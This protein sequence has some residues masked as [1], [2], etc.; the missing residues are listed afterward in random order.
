[1]KRVS[2]VIGCQSGQ[3]ILQQHLGEAAD[4]LETLG[5]SARVCES[6]KGPLTF[7]KCTF[8]YDSDNPRD[9]V[10]VCRH[11]VAAAVAK[12]VVAT[13]EPAVLYRHLELNY[14]FLDD[15]EQDEISQMATSIAGTKRRSGALFGMPRTVPAGSG[16]PDR[17]IVG[18]VRE[19]LKESHLLV[20]EGFVTFRLKDYIAA[21]GDVVQEA[22]DAFLV[23]REYREFVRLLRYF[24]DVQEPRTGL[25]HVFIKPGEAF[26][27]CDAEGNSMD[28][29]YLASLVTELAETE[30]S[31]EDLLVSVLITLAPERIVLHCPKERLDEEAVRTV[32]DVFYRRVSLCTGCSKC[33]ELRADRSKL[34]SNHTN[35]DL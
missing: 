29:R 31:H 33:S 20:V 10:G 15:T 35:Q 24:V 28:D 6:Q 7:Y 22:V 19:Y 21:L 2:W 9:L 4:Y 25:T 11:N 16:Q 30:V 18:R 3:E 27:V 13:W 12:S 32:R 8:E 23:E 14:D 26:E 17:E 5:A 34:S 1:M